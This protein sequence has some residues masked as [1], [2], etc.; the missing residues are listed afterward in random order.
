MDIDI[1]PARISDLKSICEKTSTPKF[2]GFLT[3]DESAFCEKLL[4]NTAKHYFFGGY[5]GAERTVLCVAPDWCD[6][7]VYPITAITFKYRRCD[8]LT[9]RDFLGALMSLGIARETVG[10]ILIEDGRAVVFM[11]CEISD[12]VNSQI[13]KIGR[14]GV[15][16]SNGYDEP[17]PEIGKKEHLSATVAST[18]LDCVIS[19]IC[20]FSRKDAAKVIADGMVSV[21]SVCCQKA[22]FAVTAGN[23]VTVRQK[24]RYEITDCDLFT[25][26]G[27]IILNYSKY[28]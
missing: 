12:Y 7:P 24:G 4:G 15:T 3:T 23:T 9:H 8:T 14:V 20:G 19:A 5:T 25:K 13:R 27:R 17:L 21:N 22:T 26:K 1:L 10:D 18:R 2:L 11:L 28:K 16:L 6:R